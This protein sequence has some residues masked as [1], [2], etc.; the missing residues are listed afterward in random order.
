MSLRVAAL[1]YLGV[2]AAKLRRDAVTSL[3]DV[4]S[5]QALLTRLDEASRDDEAG[6]DA[7]INDEKEENK[8]E[9]S[10][11]DEVRLLENFCY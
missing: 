7:M 1:D 2:V 4:K 8:E 3:T 5:V 11:K 10:E 6:N 9:K